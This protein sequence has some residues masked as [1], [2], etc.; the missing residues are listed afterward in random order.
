MATNV[1]TSFVMAVLNAAATLSATLDSVLSQS[2]S[3]FQLIVVDDGSTDQTPA[4]LARYA[5][6]D[7]RLLILTQ[8]NAGLTRALISGC[9]AATGRYIA[10]HDAGDRSHPER[11]SLQREVLDRDSSVA[12]VSCWTEVIGPAEEPLFVTRG[13]QA[14]EAPM[15]ILDATSPHGVV[16]GPTHHGSV[17]FRR[18]AYE[19]AGGY[20]PEFRYGQDW[21][22]WYRLAAIGRFQVVPRVL[23]TARI[24]PDSISSSA[25]SAQTQLARL[26]Y[27]ALQ[28]RSRGESDAPILRRAAEIGRSSRRAPFSRSRGLY[29]IAEALRKNGDPRAR[30]YFRDAIR[31]C[32]FHGKAWIRLAQT[33][34]R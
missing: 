16:A 32:P 31:E 18:D 24:D 15:Q 25:R 23:Y 12:F 22:L 19:R 11:L 14:A 8:A 5:K 29:F 6:Q 2:D 26:S 20:R 13:P 34:F 9:A 10:R 1:T 4:V 28:A 17:L 33:W 7:A 30:A 3:D 21:D 27:A